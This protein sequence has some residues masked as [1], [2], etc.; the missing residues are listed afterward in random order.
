MP[1]SFT[2]KNQVQTHIYLLGQFRIEQQSQSIQLPTR[3][4]ESLLAH[5]ILHPGK[6]AREKIAALF[7]GDSSDTKARNSLR[8]ALAVINKNL[9]PDLFL[10]DRQI[11]QINPEYLLWVDA[12]EFEN[13]AT[14]FLADPTPEII[15]VN[16]DL[17]QADLLIDFYDDW[18]FPLR[19]HFH[20]LFID[21]L[22]QMTQQ[23]RSQ[24]EYDR[25]IDFSRKILAFDKANERAYQHLMFCYMAQGDRNAALKQYMNCK[26]SLIDELGVEPATAT[27]ALYQWIEQAPKD[28]GPFSAQITNLPIPLTSFIGRK[29]ETAEV[30]QLLSSS[31]LLTLIGPGGSGKTRMG[32]QVATDL[33]DFFEDGVWW[34]E[35]ATLTDE[36]LIPQAIAKA[37]GVQEVANQ[38]LSESISKFLRSKEILL[39]LDNCEHLIEACVQITADLLEACPYLKIIA[40]S[41]E[42]L[43]MA[44]E[45]IWRIPSLSLPDPQQISLVERL[46]KFESIRLF[47]ERASAIWSDFALTEQNAPFVA[48]ICHRLDGIPLAIELASA[49]IKVLTPEQISARLDD[50]FRLLTGGGRTAI[51]RHQTL[52]AMIDWS[53][54]LLTEDERSL[55]RG[56]GVFR[57]GW[58]LEA[59]ES[60]FSGSV[61]AGELIDLMTSLVDKSMVIR[62]RGQ[63]GEA[64]F[65]MLET[66]REYSYEKLRHSDEENQ[67][68]KRH[69]HYYLELVESVKPHLGFFLSD[70]EILSWM[71]ILDAE[72][73]NMRTGLKLAQADSALS[74][75][76]LRMAGNL[77][78]FWLTRGQLSEGRE[79]LDRILANNLNV[80][81]PILAQALLSAGFLGCWQGDFRP[82]RARL[83]QS[84]ELFEQLGEKSG[85]AFSL[86][87]LGF[88]ANGLGEHALAGTIF[89]KGLNIARDI[90]D[91]WLISFA[92]HFT[93]IGSSFQGDYELARSQFMECIGL[94]KDGY[95]NLPGIAFSLFHLGRI[96]R[97]QGDY[98][99][100]HEQ[101]AEGTQIFLQMGDRRGLGYSLSGFACLAF[102]QEEIHQ[103]ARLFGT[104]DSIRDELG[105]LLE[106]ILQSE[107]E[108]A[109]IAT[110][111]L[112]G[113]LDFRAEWSNGYGMSIEKAVQIALIG[114]SDDKN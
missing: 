47:V 90:D 41:R 88:A 10:A 17:Y 106:A 112:L 93:A 105:S 96:A 16:L 84:L 113:E 69:L 108:H 22:L 56:L 60:V 66:I 110:Q 99:S 37:L 82:A 45:N 40:T 63:G 107:Y 62:E 38:S 76:G 13:Q 55:F 34:V 19:E 94:I 25:A 73:D 15:N 51:P 2:E 18:I 79:R 91:K 42:S 114:E 78:W 87:G 28:V 9:G 44:G 20:S 50:R 102:A 11:V 8:N 23:M 72:Q 59:A 39:I 3:K 95:G 4:I 1:R 54:D 77:H 81:T 85:I 32:I 64:R 61:E 33:L 48:Q 57:G 103:A 80:S 68:R 74:E 86:H 29:R 67:I 12:H 70:R 97:I 49:R 83:E 100:A 71:K 31:R 7:W 46:L 58:T 98:V 53:Y 75:M 101:L 111:E 35:L 6:H 5:F 89:E 30:K 52:R 21:T 109:K 24:S 104:V 43:N 92:L 27:M 36:S 65:N 14:E 26:Q